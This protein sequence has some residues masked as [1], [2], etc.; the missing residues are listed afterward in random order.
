MKYGMKYMDSLRDPKYPKWGPHIGDF[1]VRK[2][3]VYQLNVVF[4]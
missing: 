2:L 3:W 4:F 1:P